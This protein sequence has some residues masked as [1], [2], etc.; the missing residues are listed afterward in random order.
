MVNKLSVMGGD[1]VKGLVVG[2]KSSDRSGD[3]RDSIGTLVGG[4][5]TS[6]N[7]EAAKANFN[8]L[9]HIL[10]QKKAQDLASHIFRQNQRPDF[11]TLKPVDRVSRFYDIQSSHIPT[12]EILQTVK[13]IG[14]G[15]RAGYMDS[16]SID[17]Q[18]QQGI[19]PTAPATGGSLA[20]LKQ[21]FGK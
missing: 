2:G 11:Q 3:I 5:Y 16:I 10:G 8:N 19:V 13:S 18:K 9:V 15:P 20:A 12:N 1:P 4:G 7:D 6:L 17:N 21:Y 14:T